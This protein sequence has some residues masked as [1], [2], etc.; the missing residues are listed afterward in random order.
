[1][2][3]ASVLLGAAVFSGAEAVDV[4]TGDLVRLDPFERGVVHVA[5]FAT[6][7]PPCVDEIDRLTEWEARYGAEGYRLVVL[8]VPERQN[9]EKLRRF[10]DERAVPGRFL[11]D[12]R[13]EALRALDADR[14][15]T[16]ILLLPGGRV[17]WRGSALAELGEATLEAVIAG[18]DPGGEPR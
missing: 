12:A 18:R 13:G 15:P 9:L 7:C 8:A 6:W 3:G 16:H 10:R 5:V 17:A 11:W 14:V 4:A 1:M 2:I